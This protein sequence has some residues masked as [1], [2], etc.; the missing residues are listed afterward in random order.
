MLS[1]YIKKQGIDNINVRVIN[2]EIAVFHLENAYRFAS[3]SSVKIEQLR[4]A[5][6]HIKEASRINFKMVGP[7]AE[8][9]QL[10]ESHLSEIMADYT[11]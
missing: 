2:R 9:M 11:K 4:L 3:R 1:I 8:E 10:C 7:D 6:M 5:E